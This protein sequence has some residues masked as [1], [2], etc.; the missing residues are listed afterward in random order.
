MAFARATGDRWVDT[1]RQKARDVVDG[2]SRNELL[3]KAVFAALL[4]ADS[5][6]LEQDALFQA[7]SSLHEAAILLK[8]TIIIREGFNSIK[9]GTVSISALLRPRWENLLTRSFPILSRNII[10]ESQPCLHEALM[11]MWSTHPYKGQWQA[12][13]GPYHHR[14]K[15]VALSDGSND[16]FDSYQ[17]PYR[18][19]SCGWRPDGSTTVRI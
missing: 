3:A 9:G 11:P 12:V 2:K 5:F 10:Q 8:S 16:S 15:S 6:N 18:R 19:V 17:S 14:L 13:E 4:C 7:L 1:L